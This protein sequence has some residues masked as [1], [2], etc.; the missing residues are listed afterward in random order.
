MGKV[1]GTKLWWNLLNNQQY[2]WERLW[3]VKYAKEEKEES[4]IQMQ[5][6]LNGSHIWNMAWRKPKPN[7]TKLFL[8]N[9]EWAGGPLLGYDAWKQRPKWSDQEQLSRIKEAMVNQRKTRVA[10]YWTQEEA[11]HKWHKWIPKE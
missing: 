9:T 8:G 5:V 3:K 4:L 10:Q 2:Q 7:P 6:S 11:H 1:L